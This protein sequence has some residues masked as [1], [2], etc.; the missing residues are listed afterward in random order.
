MSLIRLFAQVP[1]H[2]KSLIPLW[3]YYKCPH[4]DWSQTNDL[5]RC[6][7]CG[8]CRDC[9]YRKVNFVNNG[10]SKTVCFICNQYSGEWFEIHQPICRTSL[11]LCSNFYITQKR[12][13]CKNCNDNIKICLI[14]NN[15]Q[16]N[17]QKKIQ[18]NI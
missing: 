2:W 3:D 7:Y 13:I 14:C 12:E 17:I 16:K 6:S 18:K 15:I 5:L 1:P 11:E 4:C 9:D 10:L 8:I